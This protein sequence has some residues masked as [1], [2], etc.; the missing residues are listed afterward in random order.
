MKNV[1]NKKI[2]TYAF[3]VLFRLQSPDE[4]PAIHIGALLAA[5]CDDVTPGIGRK[6]YLLL[7]FDREAED[8]LSAMCSAIEDAQQAMPQAQL[9]EVGPDLLGVSEL[10]FLLGQTR[11][12]VR[13]LMQVHVNTMPEPVRAGAGQTSASVWHLSDLLVWLSA[14]RPVDPLLLAVAQASKLI[15][16]EYATWRLAQQMPQKQVRKAHQLVQKLYPVQHKVAHA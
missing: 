3:E 16:M 11:Q 15:N 14:F 2:E 12:N 10:A 8:A 4:D 6:G 9:V 1:K 5:G 7:S 13:H